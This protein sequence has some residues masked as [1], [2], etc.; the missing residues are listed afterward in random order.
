MAQQVP[1]SGAHR[2]TSGA[3]TSEQLTP[4]RVRPL[5]VPAELGMKLEEG[6]K[7]AR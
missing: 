3:E 4:S 6:G 7:V 5:Q 2:V 1:G